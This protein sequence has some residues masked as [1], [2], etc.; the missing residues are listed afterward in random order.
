MY[1][2]WRK[3]IFC[4]F[5]W[6]RLTVLYVFIIYLTPE[7]ETK[8]KKSE[9]KA[10]KTQQKCFESA[11]EM[12]S[13]MNIE[14]II[15]PSAWTNQRKKVMEKK[16][17]A[18][19]KWCKHKLGISKAKIQYQEKDETIWHYNS[20]TLEQKGYELGNNKT[21]ILD[22]YKTVKPWNDKTMKQG[23]SKTIKNQEIETPKKAKIGRQGRI[24][25]L[26]SAKAVT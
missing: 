21:I 8:S 17:N 12:Q 22:N 23:N 1:Y 7:K 2:R 26:A 11:A 9:A 16:I 19:L 24:S 20:T 25:C 14:I 15:L 6:Y 3:L 4:P 5:L 10:I 13:Q 18:T